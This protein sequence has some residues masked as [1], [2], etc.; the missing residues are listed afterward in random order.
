MLGL[1]WFDCLFQLGSPQHTYPKGAGSNYHLRSYLEGLTLPYL[2][3]A[4]TLE[5]LHVE[6]NDAWHWRT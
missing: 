2:P 3:S 1:I 4:A 6:L 5:P